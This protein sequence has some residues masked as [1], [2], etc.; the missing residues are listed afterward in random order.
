MTLFDIG[1]EGLLEEPVCLPLTATPIYDLEINQPRAEVASLRERYPDSEHALVRYH[2]TYT[3]GIANLEEILH[4][5]DNVFPRWYDRDWRE[6]SSLM[7]M[8]GLATPASAHNFHDTVRDYLQ[9]ELA[10][11]PDRAALLHLTD[12]LLAE[13]T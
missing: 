12:E 6:A 9:S 3:A 11:H 4:E 10:T 8:R 5:L 7:P 1:P 2:L 13:D